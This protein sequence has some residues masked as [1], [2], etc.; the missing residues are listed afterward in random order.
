MLT[1][2]KEQA[3]VFE[4]A[5][6]MDFEDR[7]VT[8]I[9]RFFPGHYEALQEQKTRQLIQFGI[10][11]AAAHGIVNQCDVCKFTDLMVAFGPGFEQDPKCAW[12]EKILNDQSIPTPSAKVDKLYDHG[13]ARLESRAAR[14][15]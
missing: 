15:T 2:R 4:E 9:R 8:H 13:V 14:E 3:A 1:I 5:N 11:R 12:T 6:R 7:M 10:E